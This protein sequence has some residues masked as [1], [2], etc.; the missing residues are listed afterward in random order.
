[1]SLHGTPKET[2]IYGKKIDARTLANIIKSRK[3]YNNEEIVLISCNTGNTEKEKVC[4]AQ[5]LANEM[6]ITVHAPTRYGIINIFGKYYSGTLN[7][8]RDGEFKPFYPQ[9]KE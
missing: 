5:K 2:Y 3:D 9:R 8:K 7:G 6:N 1:M 4:F